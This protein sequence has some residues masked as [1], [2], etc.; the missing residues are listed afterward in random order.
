MATTVKYAVIGLG[1]IA[2]IAAL[3]AFK[4]ARRNSALAAL[5]SG[6]K[7]KLKSLGRKYG[8]ATLAHY[9]DLEA[10]LEGVDAVYI[11]TPN[12]EHAEHAIRAARAG[13]H[14]LCEKPLAV[15][16]AECVAIVEACRDA[17]VRLMTAYRL[18]FDPITL[19]VLQQVRR[20]AIGDLRYFESAFSMRAQPGNIRTRHE[21][22]GGTVYDLG[23][24]CINA[25][26]MLFDSE[27]E[28]VFAY[29]ISGER[30]GMPEVDDTTAVVMRFR[31]NRLATFVSSFDAGEV[32]A[33]R[34]VGT[35]G[36]ISVEP[37]YE[38]AE[39]LSYTVT[40]ARGQK[41]RRG[42]KHD[43]FAAEL[44]YFSDCVQKGKEPEP[45]GEEGAWDVRVI[46]AIYESARRGEPISLR[47]FQEPGPSP[48]Q[49]S[50]PPPVKKPR[51]IKAAPPKR[52]G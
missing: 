2:Q 20:G 28:Q 10:A 5:I 37:G 30:S 12:S 17:N 11:A 21:T 47:E 19:D 34:I 4:H 9:D 29:A 8:V 41:T 44:M 6:D 46:D 38:Y 45:S 7:Q 24:Y 35:K 1:Y 3:P 25:A 33:Y 50:S 42:R 31:G 22:G 49:R 51:L 23:I 26:R 39:P 13:K 36:S 14:V 43:Q 27:P 48:R 52:K 32:S 15:T 40:T 16:D 18:H